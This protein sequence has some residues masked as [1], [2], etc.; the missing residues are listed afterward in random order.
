MRTL[1]WAVAAAVAFAMPAFAQV[2][3]KWTDAE[4]KVQYSDQPPKSFK[5]P[6]TRIEPDAVAAPK[7]AAPRP[8]EKALP[9]GVKPPEPVDLARERRERRERLQAKLDEARARVEA[10]SKALEEG[11]DRRD[12]D[13]QFIQQRV[14]DPNG[15]VNCRKVKDAATGK[16]VLICGTPVLNEQ[17]FDR[18]AQLEAELK[19]AEESLT[20]AER[21]YRRGV[22]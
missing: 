5:G 16:E 19:A 14:K 1:A 12:G 10:A 8:P 21:A 20:E 22:D 11:R 18:V 6:V 15:R 2:L 9:D 4:G 13:Q 3:Y 7:V 17:Y